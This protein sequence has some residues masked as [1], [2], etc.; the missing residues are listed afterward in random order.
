MTRFWLSMVVAVLSMVLLS[1]VYGQE[2]PVN[3]EDVND[4]WRVW[5]G[6]GTN[7]EF[8]KMEELRFGYKGLLPDIELA[9]GVL[10]KDAPE[11]GVEDWPIRGYAIAHAID[12]EMIASALGKE[13]TLPK[14][15]VYAGLFAE[16]SYD[17]ENEWGGGYVVGALVDWP[18]KWQTYGEYQR[19]IFNTSNEDDAFFVGLVRRLK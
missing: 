16:Y 17:R 19:N 10:H 14:G 4:G 2:V 5:V 9:V 6:L 13:L 3:P 18:R 11:E 15:N 7:P 1:T 8:G 12:A